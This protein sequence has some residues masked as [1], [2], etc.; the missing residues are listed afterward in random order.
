M[1]FIEELYYGNINPNKKLRFD[2]RSFLLSF[3]VFNLIYKLLGVNINIKFMF[4]ENKTKT[5]KLLKPKLLTFGFKCGM[6]YMKGRIKMKKAYIAPL[7]PLQDEY[8]NQIYFLE[9]LIDA[10]TKLEVYKTKMLD[11]KVDSSWLL[12]T[13]QQKEA[14]ASSQLEGTRATLD[15]V[16]INQVEKKTDDVNINE[17]MN[18][19]I[20]T[21]Q[22]YDSLRKRDFTNEFFLGLHTTLMRGNV[23]KPSLV[24]EYRKDQNY[25]GKND[26]THTITFIPPTADSVPELMDNLIEYINKAD[27]NFRPLVR[28]AIIHAQFETIHPFEDG[29]GRVGRMLIPM[30]LFAQRQIELPCLFVSE[31]LERNKPKYYTLLNNIR[32]KNDWN[33]WIKFFLATVVKQCDKYIGIITDIN[34]LY[35]KHLKTACDLARSSN[36]VDIINAIYQYPITSAKQIAEITKLPMTSIN[37]YLSQ[38]MESKIIYSDNKARNRKFFCIDLLDVLRS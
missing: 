38:L 35:E 12:P 11:S 19:Y 30:Y 7:L 15:G 3:V 10:T 23:R 17:V 20:A 22:G 31:A 28:T 36:M 29:N 21:Q 13:F 4:F 8:I 5:L 27:D 9:E 37:R 26:E 18:Y 24:G 16:L 2:N 6:I 33:E 14:L 32:E 25:I 1:N 34:N